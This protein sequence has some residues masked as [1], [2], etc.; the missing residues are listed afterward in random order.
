M[1]L[2]P[3]SQFSAADGDDCVLLALFH[4]LPRCKVDRVRRWECKREKLIISCDLWWIFKHHFHTFLFCNIIISWGKKE[5][6]VRRKE[7]S[8]Y[9]L[10]YSSLTHAHKCTHMG[11]RWKFHTLLLC[12]WLRG[13][14]ANREKGQQVSETGQRVSHLYEHSFLHETDGFVK[15]SLS[16]AWPYS[17]PA[18]H[19]CCQGMSF[20][21]QLWLYDLFSS[22]TMGKKQQKTDPGDERWKKPFF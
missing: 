6:N 8:E 14:E 7:S 13:R 4:S 16:K 2:N 17:S 5:C 12:H 3:D 19:S 11:S 9:T 21:S 10:H 15:Y 22:I 18:F 1:P 20:L